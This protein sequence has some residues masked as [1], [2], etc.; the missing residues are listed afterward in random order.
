MVN[1]ATTTSVHLSS[2]LSKTASLFKSEVADSTAPLGKY[3]WMKL[4][5]AVVATV[6]TFEIKAFALLQKHQF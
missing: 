6:L 1:K 4:S 5:N 3:N 2:C